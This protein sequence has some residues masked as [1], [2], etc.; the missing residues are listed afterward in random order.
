MVWVSAP[1]EAERLMALGDDE[2]SERGGARQSHSILGRVEVQPGRHVFPLAIER[3]R[4]FAEDRIA[5]VGESAHVLPPIGAQGLNMGLRDAADIAE[6]VGQALGRGEDP[7]APNVLSR[8][9]A[10]A[11]AGRHAAGPGR[12]TSPT[13][14]C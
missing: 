6:I 3:P 9:Q 11:A 4:Q 7:G 10:R 8:Y 12:S 5:L 2:L 14:R 13:A 1:K